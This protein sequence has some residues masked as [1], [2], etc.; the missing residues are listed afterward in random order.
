MEA[1]TTVAS[2][3][4]AQRKTRSSKLARNTSLLIAAVALLLLVALLSLMTG[5]ISI[6]AHDV[7]TALFHADDSEA[8]QIV[9]NLRLPRILT[10]MLAG[11]CLAIS[12]AFL[13][14]IFRNPLADPGIIGVSAGGG[15]AAVV[16]MILYPAQIAFLPISAF[17]GA[18]VASAVVYLL[19]WRG[20]A[21]PLRLVLAGV[22]VNSLLG[23]AMTALMIVNSEKVQSVLPWISGSLNGRSWPHFETLLPYAIVGGIASLLLIKQANLLVFGDDAAKLLGSR[24]EI[25]RLLIVAVSA[26]LAGAAISIVGMVGFVGL[27]MPHII[28]M[29]SG[30]DYRILL[31]LSAIGG[32]TLVIAADTAARSWFDPIEFPVGILLALIGAPFFLYLLRRGLAR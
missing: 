19:A 20:G 6:P 29:V 5:A 1:T 28:R 15:L 18:I 10:G 21:S 13:Q 25:G 27:V 14:G 23:A 12:G 16:I 30:S 9:W 32:A 2:R 7:W 22:A 26:F 24:V 8:R 11:G 3:S 31:P 4:P 17:G